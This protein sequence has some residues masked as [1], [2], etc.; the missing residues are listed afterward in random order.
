MTI[1]KTTFLNDFNSLNAKQN[2]IEKVF[3]IFFG[4]DFTK[5][6]CPVYENV[7]N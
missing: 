3:I 1:F 4:H 6:T 2:Y 5:R 7:A